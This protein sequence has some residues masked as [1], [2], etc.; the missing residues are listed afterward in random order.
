MNTLYED[1]MAD[2]EL[3]DVDA[4][5]S[6]CMAGAGQPGFSVQNDAR[7]SIS[8]KM[9]TMYDDSGSVDEAAMD[10]VGEEEIELALVDL[11]CRE[12]TGYQD[13]ME[14][15]QF[16]LEQQFIDDHKAELE[17]FRAD[18]EQGN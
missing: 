15:V 7:S 11:D 18:A 12:E 14:S 4:E 5:W 17:A 2:P 16:K 10:A 9:N 8:D 1:M 6:A 13:T 3:L